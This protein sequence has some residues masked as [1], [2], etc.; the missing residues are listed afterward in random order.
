[1]TKNISLVFEMR[2]LCHF[3]KG[4]SFFK[5]NNNNFSDNS[6]LNHDFVTTYSKIKSLS[7]DK[8]FEYIIVVFL[9]MNM[10]ILVPSN[11]DK[12]QQCLSDDD[13]ALNIIWKRINNKR[14][15]PIP[16]LVLNVNF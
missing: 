16:K 15:A 1:M 5:I 10:F 4:L 3:Y 8:Q 2:N 9:K 11:I 14:L 13:N 7:F 6:F 12:L